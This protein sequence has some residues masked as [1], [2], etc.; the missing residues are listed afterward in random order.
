MEEA[1]KIALVDSGRESIVDKKI[2]KNVEKDSLQSKLLLRVSAKEI[3]FDSVDFRFT[4]F[5]NC[6]LRKCRFNN[7]NFTGCKFINTNFYGSQFEGCQFDYAFFERTLVD[8]S[9]LDNCCPG[10]DNLKL[11][12][13]RTLR[14]NF[15]QIGDIDG[16]NKAIHVELQATEIFLYKAWNSNEAYYRKKYS[17][18]DR[19]IMFFR[20]LT[21][22]LLDL[23]WGNG[24]SI[25]KL[26]RALA[27][28]IGIILVAD[29]YYFVSQET[30]CFQMFSRAV[31]L[32]LG[33]LIPEEY[34]PLYVSSISF[35]RLLML[36]FFMSIIIKRFNKR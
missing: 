36:G 22:K 9:I 5:D 30:D 10:W 16:V 19:G 32:F 11:R 3:S 27:I 13:A 4:Y 31:A 34:P 26:L 8:N 7:C 15:H 28:C 29:K 35:V 1:Y 21:F 17:K 18:V 20:W 14:V 25:F 12:F 24:E 33:V 23:I 6:Y 2:T